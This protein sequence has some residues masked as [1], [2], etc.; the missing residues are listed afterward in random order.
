MMTRR[1]VLAIG[2]TTP[3][4]A[5]VP[6][7]LAFAPGQFWN[8]RPASEW[9]EKEI[10]QLLSRSP[11]AK[12]A[13]TQ[14]KLPGGDGPQSGGPGGGGGGMG[15]PPGGGGGIRDFGNSTITTSG[16]RVTGGGWSGCDYGCILVASCY[17]DR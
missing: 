7:L 17:R 8:E 12:D 6:R 4:W 10:E 2:I 14:F 13:E 5:G 9:S 16:S 15:V 1:R 11:W 3:V